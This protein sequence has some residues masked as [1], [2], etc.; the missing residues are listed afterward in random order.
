MYIYAVEHA[1]ISDDYSDNASSTSTFIPDTDAIA[2]L[3]VTAYCAASSARS[4]SYCKHS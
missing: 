4:C 1:V 2:S 3:C